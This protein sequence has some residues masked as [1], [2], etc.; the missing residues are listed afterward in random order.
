MQRGT[1]PLT[2]RQLIDGYFMEHRVQ[3]LELAAYLDRL[4][5][6]VDRSAQDDCRVRAR[7]EAGRF[8]CGDVPG[9]AA[10]ILWV[11]SDPEI[12][13][14]MTRDRQN[15]CGAFGGREEARR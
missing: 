7:R 1:C 15:A 5:R 8:L 2:Q 11:L 6:S 9:G 4:D 10:A 14:L 3:V 12:D 13:P